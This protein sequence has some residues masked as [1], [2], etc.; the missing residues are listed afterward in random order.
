[1]RTPHIPTHQPAQSDGHSTERVPPSRNP[2]DELASLADNPLDDFLT[3]D[4]ASS[5]QDDDAEEPWAPPNHRRGS[6]RRNRATG[7]PTVVRVLAW[8]LTLACLVTL[9]DRW[10]L[11][12]AEHKASERLKDQL[13]LAAAPEVRIGGFPFLSQLA[14]QRLDSVRIT[15]PGIPARRVTLTQVTATA[16]DIR[17]DGD[18][19]T[20]V[21]GALVRRVHGRVL[22]SF[23]DMNRELGA[24]QVSFTAH[25]PGRVRAHGDL[26]VAGNDLRVRADVRI[27]REGAR[28]IAT[29]VDGMRLDI[30]DLATYRPGTGP[31]EGLHL[32]RASARRLTR[33]AE[34]IRAFLAVPEIVR[35]LG[36]PDSAVRA[37][38]HDEDRLHQLTGAPRFLHDLTRMNLV[39]VA[40]AH[41]GLLKRLG[42]DLSLLTALTK[43][44]RPQIADRFSFS[45]QL[46]KPPS[47]A[48]RLQRVTV[49]KDGIHADVTGSGLLLGH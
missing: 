23:A 6:R 5:S 9:A 7:L 10:A 14:A 29:S 39:D 31:A 30:G 19:P 2:Y 16:H 12:Y 1:M 48:L 13:H 45:F 21:R 11:L 22:L 41:P 49:H 28:G 44:T 18:G 15:V 46:P 24:S 3:E 17:I 20:A 43:L 42:L 4:S 36:V 27:R 38:L 8:A 26:R 33:E 40:V 32:T 34:K 47:G 35:R 25:G 37:A